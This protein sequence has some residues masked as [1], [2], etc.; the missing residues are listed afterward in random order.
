[1]CQETARL[2]LKLK[3]QHCYDRGVNDLDKALQAGGILLENI[4]KEKN[5][6]NEETQLKT[7]EEMNTGTGKQTDCLLGFS[8]ALSKWGN[9]SLGKVR[10]EF[11]LKTNGQVK[12][13][14][15]TDCSPGVNYEHCYHRYA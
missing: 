4:Q 10:N 9:I 6:R 1:M 3:T 7:S 2:E 11:E 12:T 8:T 14:L 5:V 15:L 13:D